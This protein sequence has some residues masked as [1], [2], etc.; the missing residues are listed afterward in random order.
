M[1][2]AG[3]EPGRNLAGKLLNEPG[4]PPRCCIVVRVSGEDGAAPCTAERAG[5][6]RGAYDFEPFIPKT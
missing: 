1:E 3:K 2:A 5:G 4:M 6:C